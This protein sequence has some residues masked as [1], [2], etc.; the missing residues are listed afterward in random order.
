MKKLIIILTVLL[1][2]VMG[3]NQLNA[4]QGVSRYFYTALTP[5]G[6]WIELDYGVV[7]WRPIIMDVNWS[8]Y[9]QGRWIWTVDG[10]YW[11]SYERFGYITYHYGRWYYDDYYGWIWV[12]GYEYAPAWVEWRYD[13]AYIGWAP[14]PPYATFSVTV[15]IYFTRTYYTPY[16]YWNFVNYNYFY[17]P[18]VYKH[19]VAPRYKYR[20][21]S[22]T[23]YRTNYTYYNGRVRNNG[24]DVNIIRTRGGQKIRR[25]DV[26]RTS[27]IQSLDRN[28]NN[29]NGKIK[30][31]YL[32]RDELK[33]NEVRD[34]NFK[35]G[36]RKTTLDVSKIRTSGFTKR[37]DNN[38]NRLE[39]RKIDRKKEFDKTKVIIN[40][41]YKQDVTVNR[42]KNDNRN[43]RNDVRKNEKI[44]KQDNRD[45]KLKTQK[46]KEVKR[47]V[48]VNTQ[49]TDNKT[50]LTRKKNVKTTKT[51]RT[52]TGNNNKKKKT[53]NTK[54]QNRNK[55]N[56]DVK[57]NRNKIS[58]RNRNR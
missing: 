52:N 15:G 20:I 34:V 7:V 50:K 1:W 31:F 51:V 5:Y 28:R 38:I 56:R 39:K 30:T 17:N 41:D 44:R 21:Y 40:K 49:R 35:R 11:K 37:N 24:V 46:K 58:N 36:D 23:K 55:N 2:G 14:L 8:P 4:Q 22:Q 26:I 12:P 6:Q 3:S 10:W 43:S 33:R 25:R 13:N 18:Y 32:S 19:F 53:L 42:N 9:T 57:R 29:S 16:N 45:M 47:N 27:D 54:T 48:D